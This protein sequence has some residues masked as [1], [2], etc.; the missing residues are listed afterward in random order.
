MDDFYLARIIRMRHIPPATPIAEGVY[1]ITSTERASHLAY[2]LTLPDLL[3]EVQKDLGINE[4][5]SFIA[6]VKN[7]AIP[8]PGNV[9][10]PKGAEYP[11]SIM[12]KFRGRRWMPL[13]PE[14]L[15]YDNTQ[16]LVIG[17]GMENVDKATAEQ[18]QDGKDDNK[19]TPAQ[20]MDKLEDEVS[21]TR[22]L[23]IFQVEV[24]S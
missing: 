13:E 9:S 12:E 20:E 24:G 3:G 2:H 7:P 8:P 19:E 22:P 14:L 15:D 17:E 18:E 6:S 16:I 5:G 4:K 10:L 1:A 21:P 23:F 11:Q